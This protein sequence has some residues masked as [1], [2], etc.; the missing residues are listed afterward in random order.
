ME[1]RTNSGNAQFNLNAISDYWNITTD[2]VEIFSP[3]L[4]VRAR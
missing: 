2:G 3:I 4:I 1:D